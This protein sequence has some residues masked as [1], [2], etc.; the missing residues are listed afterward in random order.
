M[1]RVLVGTSAHHPAANEPFSLNATPP[2]FWTWSQQAGL[3]TR[4]KREKDALEAKLE[5]Q[6]AV[7]ARA[8]EHLKVITTTSSI[9]TLVSDR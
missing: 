5:E 4:L 9:F 1:L 3:T 2:C 8:N 7:L 6:A